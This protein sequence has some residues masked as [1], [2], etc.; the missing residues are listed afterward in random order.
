M[1][2]SDLGAKGVK[3]IAFMPNIGLP[4]K[5][6]VENAYDIARGI[7]AAAREYNSYVIGGDMNQTSEVIISGLAIGIVE[8]ERIM[9]R[10]GNVKPGDYL[11]TTGTFGLTSAALKHLIEG[12]DLPET[13]A[14]TILGS[15]YSPRASIKEGIALSS[16]RGVNSCIDSSDGL[17]MSLFDL[18]RSTGHGYKIITMPIDPLVKKFAEI[19]KLD[20]VSL[21]FYGGEE[22]HLIF[23]FSPKY[24][25]KVQASL[26][27]VGS[28]LII[29]GKVTS[30]KKII[31][32][33]G[34]QDIPILPKG[35]E[36]F[37]K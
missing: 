23:T 36:H 37:T 20:P 15:I 6:P 1:N 29:I 12:Y 35:W 16:S 18:Q 24:I 21:A 7:E 2:F 14:N 17:A 34:S 27:Q 26:C 28:E 22:Y 32:Q 9:K 30:N 13:I 5:Y 10:A 31:Y 19:N 3:P 11:A 25:K 4:K 33:S 8:K